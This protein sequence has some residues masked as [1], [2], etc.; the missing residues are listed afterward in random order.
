M[1]QPTF[2]RSESFWPFEAYFGA[3]SQQGSDMEDEVESELLVP[4]TGTT[5][6]WCHHHILVAV[7]W[8]V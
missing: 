2:G 7:C 4:E 6:I 3:W 8:A 5:G 1:G